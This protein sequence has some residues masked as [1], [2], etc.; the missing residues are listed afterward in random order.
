MGEDAGQV[1]KGSAPQTLAALRNGLVNLL[2]ALG[3]TNLADAL[4]HDG[5]FAH[6]AVQLL[7]ASLARR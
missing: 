7:S 1:R 5:A 3:W 4:R 6:R 2:R